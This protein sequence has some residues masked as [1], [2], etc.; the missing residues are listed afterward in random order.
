MKYTIH[1][2]R[3]TQIAEAQRLG[4]LSFW[5][6]RIGLKFVSIAMGSK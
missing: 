5:V 3:G 4:Y 2:E 1:Q 6:N